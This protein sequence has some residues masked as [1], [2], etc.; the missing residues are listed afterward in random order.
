MA[1]STSET[2]ALYKQKYRALVTR[3]ND[4][5]KSIKEVIADLIIEN[6]A[7]R[8]SLGSST[9]LKPKRYQIPDDLFNP[10]YDSKLLNKIENS[11]KKT[12]LIIW[13]GSPGNYYSTITNIE[14]LD[15]NIERLVFSKD[16]DISEYPDFMERLE[17][18]KHIAKR[19]NAKFN[20]PDESALIK[21]C[22]RN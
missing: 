17:R 20:V 5:I 7:L 12:S 9:G 11:A 22:E 2:D 13:E 21:Y 4:K 18:S 15:L 8:Q 16:M 3:S 1:K 19:K 6:A 10:K 14:K